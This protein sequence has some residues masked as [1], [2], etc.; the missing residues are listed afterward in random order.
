MSWLLGLAIGMCACAHAPEDNMAS[1]VDLVTATHSPT[2]GSQAD[3]ESD[4]GL[5]SPTP[6]ST[7]CNPDLPGTRVCSQI[8]PTCWC[9]RIGSGA[10]RVLLLPVSTVGGRR[11][12]LGASQPRALNTSSILL[13]ALALLGNGDS[14][15]HGDLRGCAGVGRGDWQAGHQAART[16]QEVTAAAFR[17]DRSRPLRL[18]P[19]VIACAPARRAACTRLPWATDVGMSLLS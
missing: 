13:C 15:P 6:A 16:S 17:S 3:G 18:D 19:P 5:D 9:K 14:S 1:E 7:L 11:V 2:F 8:D 10:H 12:L 4:V